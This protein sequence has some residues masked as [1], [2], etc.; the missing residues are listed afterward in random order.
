[1]AVEYEG[2]VIIG[3]DSRT[4]SGYVSISYCKPLKLVNY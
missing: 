3:A 2:G 1:M 4:T